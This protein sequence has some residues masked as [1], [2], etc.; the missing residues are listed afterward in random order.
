MKN[1]LSQDS[2]ILNDV[3][4][5]IEQSRQQ[6]AIA[7]N[8]TIT[9]LYWQV[10]KRINEEILGGQRADHG[11]SVI[12]G[13]SDQLTMDYGRGW[14]K[15]HLWHCVKFAQVFDDKE[16]VYTVCRQLS[17]SH[18]RLVFYMDDPLKREFYIEICKL[19]KWSVRTFR[20]RIKSMLYERTAISKK[21][22]ETIKKDLQNLRDTQQITPDLVFRDP[23]FLGLKDVYSERLK[24]SYQ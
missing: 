5:L 19:E 8:A 13:L 24:L 2:A 10:G 18:L 22:D 11:K 6:V 12:Q 1:E 3:K 17:W 7:V 16:I 23:Y 4:T 14:S 15:K 9:M 20:E 21:P